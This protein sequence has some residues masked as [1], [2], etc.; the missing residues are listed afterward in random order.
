MNVSGHGTGQSA[1]HKR[2]LSHSAAPQ[3]YGANTLLKFH[4]INAAVIVIRSL[5]M[6]IHAFRDPFVRCII[7]MLRPSRLS[8]SLRCR[9]EVLPV[10]AGVPV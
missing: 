7:V 4:Y 5:P 1:D 8:R 9:P 3:S 6:V 2:V 10:P